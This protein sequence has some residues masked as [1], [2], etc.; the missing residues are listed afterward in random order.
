MRVGCAVLTGFAS[1]LRK[2]YDRVGYQKTFCDN[3]IHSWAVTKTSEEQLGPE[4]EPPRIEWETPLPVQM[5]TRRC[6][7]KF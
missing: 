2:R 1:Q 3:H 6:T 4:V 7:G 5:S